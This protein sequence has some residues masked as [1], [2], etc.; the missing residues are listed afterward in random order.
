[1]KIS[2][3][4][5]KLFPCFI[6]FILLFPLFSGC[7]RQTDIGLINP[8]PTLE[9]ISSV[10]PTSGNSTKIPALQHTPLNTVTE[11]S[12][13]SEATVTPIVE[14]IIDQSFSPDGMWIAKVAILEN[15]ATMRVQSLIDTELFW[16]IP[17]IKQSGLRRIPQAFHWSSDGATL[18]YT[19]LPTYGDGCIGRW[20]WNGL[21]LYKLALESGITTDITKSTGY[22]LSISPDEKKLAYLGSQHVSESDTNDV[23]GVIDLITGNRVETEIE[24]TYDPTTLLWPIDLVWSPDSRLLVF[25]L[26]VNPCEESINRFSIIKVNTLNL[27]QTILVSE[28]INWYHPYEWK[29][30]E[31]VVLRES[32]GQKWE[33]NLNTG[34]ITRRD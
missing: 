14:T 29:E 10:T 34:E 23:I 12:I 19:Y 3:K 28:L 25:G 2:G 17:E 30:I 27:E 7:Q 21:G 1:M 11:T 9:I 33:L 24:T 8:T 15:R 4:Y 20:A 31:K 32:N 26:V 16:V 22:W 6:V 18:Y 13:T 5:E